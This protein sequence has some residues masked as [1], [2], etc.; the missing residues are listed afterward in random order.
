MQT[1]EFHIRNDFPKPIKKALRALSTQAEE[2]ELRRAL[3][4]LSRD[5]D[6]WRAGKIDSFELAHRIHVFHDGPNRKI[7]NFYDSRLDLDFIV[8]RA[9][10]EGLI[11]KDSISNEV[12]PYVEKCL[13]FFRDDARR[14]THPRAQP[15]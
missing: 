11:S 14:D 2:A 13:A 12:A 6:L 9:L 1:N 5:F 15:S 10:H 4:P 7:F 3:E 8:A